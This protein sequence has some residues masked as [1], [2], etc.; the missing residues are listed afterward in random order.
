MGTSD[1]WITCEKSGRW[2]AALRIALE[3]RK[4]ALPGSRIL[5]TRSLAELDLAIKEHEAA[6]VLVE[7][8]PESTADI[9]SYL[10]KNGSRRARLVAGRSASGAASAVSSESATMW[11]TG[12]V[13]VASQIFVRRRSS[14]ASP[15]PPRAAR[16]IRR[17]DMVRLLALVRW[18]D[19]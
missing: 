13:P 17:E 4:C 19:H 11:T 6:F 7:I 8:R 12:T 9:L 16:R 1:S 15:A 18:A 5:E 2:A 10:A 3:R 14:R